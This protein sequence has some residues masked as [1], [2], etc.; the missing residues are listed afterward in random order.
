MADTVFTSPDPRESEEIRRILAEHGLHPEMR[1]GPDP[2]T[3]VGGW[4]FGGGLATFYNVVVPEAHVERARKL[5]ARLAGPGLIPARVEEPVEESPPPQRAPIGIALWVLGALY[6]GSLTAF[7]VNAPSGA[8]LALYLAMHL[9]I[10]IVILL[11]VRSAR[12]RTR[13]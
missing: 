1:L 7:C 6:V 8:D 3:H 12:R 5:L 4:V 11:A 2:V 13:T 10:G 9:G